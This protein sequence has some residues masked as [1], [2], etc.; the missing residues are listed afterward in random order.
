MWQPPNCRSFSKNC[1]FFSVQCDTTR[2]VLECLA[3]KSH[4]IQFL[5]LFRNQ[6]VNM[7]VRLTVLRSSNRFL[8]RIGLGTL[9]PIAVHN[10]DLPRSYVQFANV[11]LFS[12]TYVPIV[13]Y[14]FELS[15]DFDHI[16][17]ALY[18][19]IAATLF[20]SLHLNCIINDLLI[21]RTLKHLEEVVLK[22][23]WNGSIRKIKKNENYKNIC[24]IRIFTQDCK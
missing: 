15:I 21:Q 5:S 11:F 8:R 1:M 12:I 3:S 10:H 14:L 6:I 9:P 7:S 19:F 23:E 2:L 17:A 24:E 18:L 16:N 20:L 13:V 22:S 4:V